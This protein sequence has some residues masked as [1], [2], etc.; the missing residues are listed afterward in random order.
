MFKPNQFQTKK[1]I[2]KC[3]AISNISFA[4]KLET[5][6]VFCNILKLEPKNDPINLT[7]LPFIPLPNTISK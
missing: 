7:N 2:L 1:N 6:S 3:F 5:R 4:I